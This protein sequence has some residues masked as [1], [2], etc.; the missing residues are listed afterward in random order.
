VILYECLNLFQAKKRKRLFHTHIGL[1]LL[2]LSS[3]LNGFGGDLNYFAKIADLF[4]NSTTFF[5]CPKC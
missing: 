3:Y 4:R 2:L 1:K 5:M